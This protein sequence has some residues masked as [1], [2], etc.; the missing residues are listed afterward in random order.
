MKNWSIICLCIFL[1]I[2]LINPKTRIVHIIVEQVKIYKN[3]STNKYYWLDFT[4]FIIVPII[5]SVIIAINL[6]LDKIVAHAETIITVFSL[7]A[8]LPLSFLAL[9][10][11]KMLSKPKE[12]EVAKEAFVSITVDILYSMMVISII[13][14]A[15]F[16]RG[17]AICEKIVVGVIAFLVIKI[18]LNILMILKRVF[19]IWKIVEN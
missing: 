3:D 7:I 2:V 16:L 1:F 19:A 4:T 18:A 17:S 14:V 11:D 13:I 5:I 15:A 9:F 6:P 8:T 12:K 10:I